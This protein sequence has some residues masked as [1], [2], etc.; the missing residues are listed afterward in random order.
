MGATE[1]LGAIVTARTEPTDIEEAQ[2]AQIEIL[3]RIIKRSRTAM[4]TAFTLIE[5]VHR[6]CEDEG[7]LDWTGVDPSALNASIEELQRMM[8]AIGALNL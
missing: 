3:K 7:G 5:E 8:D 4:G 6:N 1:G 2:A